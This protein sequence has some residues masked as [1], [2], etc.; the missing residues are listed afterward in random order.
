MNTSQNGADP[1]QWLLEELILALS[2][3]AR[4]AE[5]QVA[6]LDTLGTDRSADE[7]ALELDDVAEAAL[8]AE[9]LSE[10]QRTLLRDLDRQLGEMSGSDHAELWSHEALRTSPAWTEVRARARATLSELHA[11]RVTSSWPSRRAA[12]GSA[13]PT[14]DVIEP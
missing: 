4:P 8:A 10:T 9:L 7:L 1:R 11:E 6:Y 5:G 12:I 13:A 3:L 14:V 2:R